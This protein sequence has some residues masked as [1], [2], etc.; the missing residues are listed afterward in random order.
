VA[1]TLGRARCSI[2]AARAAILAVASAACASFPTE[3]DRLLWPTPA[4]GMVVAEQPL[5]SAAGAEILDRGGNAADAA[6][7]AAL[8]LAVV[9]PQA[10]NLG[11]GGFALWVPH[12][13]RQEELCLDFRETCPAALT[14]QDFV[15]ADGAPIVSAARS[16]ALSAGVPGTPEGLVA[17]HARLGR[18]SFAQVAAP[19]IELARRGFAL[20]EYSARVLAEPEIAAKLAADPTARELFYPGG[21]PIKAGQTL[22]Q[23]ALA[24]ALERLV[25]AGPDAFSTG[26]LGAAVVQRAREAG[27]R[28]TL[29]DLEAYEPRWREPLR[30]WFR[31]YEVLTAPPPSAGGVTLLQVLALLDG[32][33]MDAERADAGRAQPGEAGAAGGDPLGL[34]PRALHWWIE[35]LRAA[36][37][38]RRA[39]LGDPDF[40]DVP[41]AELLAPEWIVE[42][43]IAIGED[44][45]PD[46]GPWERRESGGETTHVC[47][48]DADGNAVSLTTSLNERFGCGVMVPEGGYFLNDTLDD[49]ALVPGVPTGG[50]LVDE[51][52]NAPAPGKRPLSS[53]TPTVLRA[54]GASVSLV[55]GS[56]G[57][58]RIVSAIAQVLLRVLV[59]E[60]PLAEAI[61]APRLHQQGTPAATEFEPGWDAALL[62]SLRDRGHQIALPGRRWASVQAIQLSPRAAPLGVSDAR[63]GGAPA[64]QRSRE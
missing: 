45:Q 24:A 4:F 20:D 63:R 57:G 40:V 27:G 12:D 46:V 16:T 17:F 29:A 62:E 9:Y 23:P 26:A 3:T 35:A 30:G 54:N 22:R 28:L 56:P 47:A 51:T 34:T 64:A 25:T 50:G 7:A 41:V 31:G 14:P 43:R 53:M 49:F 11:G 15:G 61:A 37:A 32:F 2:A 5:A 59:Y 39:H 55:L 60:Q 42:R 33:P 1:A 18:L 13:A 52:L 10:G 21:L 58:P 8:A 19:A 48:V 6:V 36:F 38:D 44:A